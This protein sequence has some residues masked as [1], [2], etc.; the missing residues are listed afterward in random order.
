MNLY[1]LS[2]T[3][4]HQYLL[5]KE[6]D[7]DEKRELADVV[8]NRRFRSL[9][10]VIAKK[11]M[12]PNITVHI[13]SIINRPDI[14][15]T[16][17]L[18]S[19]YLMIDLFILSSIFI[20]DPFKTNDH[21]LNLIGYEM[22]S[23]PSIFSSAILSLK[24]ISPELSVYSKKIIELFIQHHIYPKTVEELKLLEKYNFLTMYPEED[25][26]KLK[27]AMLLSHDDLVAIE[28]VDI[29]TDIKLIFS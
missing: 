11:D 17:S 1:S 10:N 20:N 22:I 28:N 2:E 23:Y 26:K 16:Y 7:F 15:K 19:Q 21:I 8:C 4:L 13:I 5:S 18:N 3:E 24:Y 14:F 6:F 29:N 27:I 9:L 25:Q 12:V